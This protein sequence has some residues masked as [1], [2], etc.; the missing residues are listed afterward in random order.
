MCLYNVL[1][2][3]V[4]FPLNILCLLPHLVQHFDCPTPFCKDV[5]ERIAQ[6]CSAEHKHHC[7]A[8]LKS[9]EICLWSLC[10]LMFRSALMR[11]PQNCPT[12]PMWWR[13]IK[14]TRTHGTACPGSTWCVAT[15]MKPSVKTHSAWWP[16]W[17][18]W[19]CTYCMALKEITNKF[20]LFQ[21]WNNNE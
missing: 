20:L 2:L 12:W 15:C 21:R 3:F 13:C 4:G 9:V 6:V 7:T 5:A 19:A 17:L 18:R 11:K 16:T 1:L 8:L 14:H 10:I